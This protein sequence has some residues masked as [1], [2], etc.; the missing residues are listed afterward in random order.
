MVMKCLTTLFCAAA[1][2]G[3]AVERAA[4]QVDDT[5]EPLLHFRK[6]PLDSQL[7]ALY[8]RPANVDDRFLRLR[9][10]ER[11]AAVV[12]CMVADGAVICEASAFYG[13]TELRKEP[14]PP[15]SIAALQSLGFTATADGWNFRYRRAFTGEP[16]FD[17]I[18]VLMLTA[19]HDAYGVREDTELDTYAPFAGD[20]VVACRR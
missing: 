7:K 10:T 1:L 12:Q 8:E 16:D 4:I 13:G 9:V 15:Q 18:A 3:L 19:L 20:M 17:A 5:L 2:V 6:C 11:P 14:L